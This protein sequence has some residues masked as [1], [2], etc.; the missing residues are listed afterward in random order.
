LLLL[1]VPLSQISP[2]PT[3]FPDVDSNLLSLL[4]EHQ[5]IYVGD[6]CVNGQAGEVHS[7]CYR[8]DALNEGAAELLGL[9]KLGEG[10]LLLLYVHVFLLE[11]ALMDLER[12]HIYLETLGLL[13]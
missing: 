10:E 7:L 2:S 1:Y 8:E 9:L 12:G 11:E 5:A 3:Y 4:R 13:L 6:S